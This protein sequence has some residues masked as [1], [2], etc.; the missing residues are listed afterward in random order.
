VSSSEYTDHPSAPDGVAKG[1]ATLDA[2][3]PLVYEE[4]H[5]LASRYLRVER[6]DHTL[7][8]TALV[9]EAYLRLAAQNHV[10]WR[11]RNQFFGIAA[12]MMRRILV[13]HAEGRNA[14]KRGGEFTRVTLDD[15]VS[16][17]DERS[18]DLVQLDDAL[19]AL[20][21]IDARQARVVE[22]RFFGG[23][24]IEET[25]EVLDISAATVKRE[26]STAKAWLRRE[27]G[28]E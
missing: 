27:L 20:A 11:D 10:D 23:L 24:G 13:N 2:L 25:A 6:A 9:N 19:S 28:A 4:L 21:T 1:K 16:W 5:G 3:L 8:P 17:S 22:L 18:V 26:W 15:S 7:Q 14:E 12:Q